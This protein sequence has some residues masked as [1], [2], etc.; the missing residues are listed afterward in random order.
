[1]RSRS[2][3]GT[4]I[5]ASLLGLAAVAIAPRLYGG[6]GDEGVDILPSGGPTP[7]SGQLAGVDRDGGSRLVSIRGSSLLLDAPRLASSSSFVAGAFTSADFLVAP[8]DPP[9]LAGGAALDLLAKGTRRISFADVP[10]LPGLPSSGRVHFGGRFEF[11]DVDPLDGEP[12]EIVSFKRT[13]ALQA[14]VLGRRSTHAGSIWPSFSTVDHF[15]VEKV[16]SGAVDL[17]AARAESI[18]RLAGTGYDVA[19]ALYA[20][21]PRGVD[22]VWVAWNVDDGRAVYD[23]EVRSR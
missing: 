11:E 4:L 9:R 5:G 20:R 17:V 16:P 21:T 7:T 23:V 22:E 6:G 19:I 14:V 2:Q 12:I 10:P 1:M 8:A 18:A 3:F 15:K 13:P